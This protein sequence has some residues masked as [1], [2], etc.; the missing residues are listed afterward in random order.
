MF[1]HQR[2]L[3]ALELSIFLLTRET[4]ATGGGTSEDREEDSRIKT[5]LLQDA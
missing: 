3:L 2:G 1:R 4:V 5:V